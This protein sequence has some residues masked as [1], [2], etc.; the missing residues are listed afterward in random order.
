MCLAGFREDAMRSRVSRP[1]TRSEEV[2][3]EVWGELLAVAGV[4]LEDNF[5]ELGG[6]SLLATQVVARVGEIFEI[7]LPLV[8]L[9]E[10]Q[11]VTAFAEAIERALI[12]DIAALDL[13]ADGV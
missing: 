4:T 10:H 2:V 8:L 3:T 12:A 9:F 1:L 11:T 6:N 5:F 13:G 7:E